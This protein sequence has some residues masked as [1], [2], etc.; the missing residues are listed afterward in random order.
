MEKD[1]EVL[2]THIK[3]SIDAIESYVSGCSREEFFSNTQKQDAVVRRFEIIGEAVSN[4]SNEFKEAHSDLNWSE[5]IGMRNV[6]IHDYASVD[7]EVVWDTLQKDIPVFKKK[8][9]GLI[10]AIS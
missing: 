3:E 10:E 4:L 8:I 9:Q 2:L 7:L 6:L 5:P 1:P